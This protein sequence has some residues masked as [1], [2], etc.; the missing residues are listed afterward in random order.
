MD[1]E[2]FNLHDVLVP[3]DYMPHP[4]VHVTNMRDGAHYQMMKRWV[5]D[6]KPSICLDVG[7]WDSWLYILLAQ[8]FPETQFITVELIQGLVEAA[9]RYIDINGLGNIKAVCGPWE[10][11]TLHHT[12]DFVTAFE[13]VEHVRK[14]DAR[15]FILK[16]CA[17]SKHIFVSLPDQKCELNQQHQWT[18]TEESIGEVMPFEHYS[19]ERQEYPG[20]TIPANFFIHCKV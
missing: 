14:E 10:A 6:L 13:V 18:P 12:F 2:I 15:E 11:V 17:C 20:S 19:L 1:Q 8:E 16:M 9:N 7:A 3:N 4:E 5:N